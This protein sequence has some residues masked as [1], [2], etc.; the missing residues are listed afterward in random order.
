AW[1]S[2]HIGGTF[3]IKGG[4]GKFSDTF[5]EQIKAN[6]GDVYLSNEIVKIDV[7][8]K[9]VTAIHTKKGEKYIADEF[10]FACDP[11]GL[12]NL[13]DSSNDVVSNYKKKLD[14]QD[15]GISLSQLYVGLDCKTTEVG[16]K[17]ADYLINNV[18]NN[19][20]NLSMSYM[21]K[22]MRIKY[23]TALESVESEEW[24]LTYF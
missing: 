4:A 3:Y 22:E 10:I 14:K 12:V 11:N 7:D 18:D 20:K 15:I 19:F 16:I 13:M 21:P 6:G 5:V 2:Y 24:D 1:G 9:K 23:Y 17:K 8:S